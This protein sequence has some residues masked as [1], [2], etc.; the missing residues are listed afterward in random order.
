MP[1]DL[2]LD[3]VI[4]F[5]RHQTGFPDRKPIG[6]DTLLEAELHVT[7]LDG[8]AL[9]EAAERHFAIVIPRDES[10][11]RELFQ[12]GPDEYLFGPE[13]FDP[14]GFSALRRRMRNEPRPFW[15]DLTVS[16]LYQILM[17]VAGHQGQRAA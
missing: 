15:R 16:E 10:A 13:E 2:S 9:L 14:V 6:P 8:P 1:H 4:R 11:F 7:G 5:V 12:V 3:E 17:R